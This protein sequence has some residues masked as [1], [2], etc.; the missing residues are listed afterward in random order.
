MKKEKKVVDML[1][2]E[3]QRK[4]WTRRL[5]YVARS[6]IAIFVRR[7]NATGSVSYTPRPGAPHVKSVRQDNFTCKGHLQNCFVTAQSTTSVEI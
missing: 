1:E 7:I 3:L 6:T 5:N 4:F 2:R